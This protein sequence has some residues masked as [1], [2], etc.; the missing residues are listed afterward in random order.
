MDYVCFKF[1]FTMCVSGPTRAGKTEL[2][3]KIIMSDLIEPAPEKVIW[4]YGEWQKGYEG[5]PCEMH[6]GVPDL[7]TLKA[8]PTRKLL[9]LD[10]LMTTIKCKDLNAIFC[11]GSH[12][13]NLSVIHI[14]QNA[15]YG[16]MRTARINSH[17][18]LLLKNPADKLQVMTLARQMYPKNQRFFLDAFEDATS[19]SFGY[20]LVDLEATTDDRLRLRTNIFAHPTVYI[21]NP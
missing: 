8:D 21:N 6:E 7:A 1:P 4:C 14:T 16:S 19:K 11:Q 9:I 12:H 15:F 17:Y 2:V 10:D 3:K 13:W 18:L 5:L 20:L